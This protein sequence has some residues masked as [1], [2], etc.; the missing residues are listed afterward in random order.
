MILRNAVYDR[1]PLPRGRRQGYVLGDAV[2][3][4]TTNVGQG[5]CQ[6][7]E[8]AAELARC[9]RVVGGDVRALR[10]YERRH[11]GDEPS[12]RKEISAA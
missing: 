8:D 7:V 6:A 5:S 2:H 12:S 11:T 9:L 10:L 4:M 3:P 1:E